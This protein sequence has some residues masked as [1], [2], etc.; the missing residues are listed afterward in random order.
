VT[1]DVDRYGIYLSD[2]NPT[3]GAEIA[4]P[5]PVVVVSAAEG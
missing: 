2:L 4:K 3:H 1:I 5:R